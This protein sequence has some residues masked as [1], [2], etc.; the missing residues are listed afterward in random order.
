MLTKYVLLPGLPAVYIHVL[1]KLC[2]LPYVAG[3]S[4][5]TLTITGSGFG[6]DDDGVTV[7][8]GMVDCDVSDVTDTQVTCTPEVGPVG[9]AE[10]AVN[11]ATKG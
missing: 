10:V 8:I 9:E 1:L 2:C 4:D 7:T 11:V 5:V 6:E 3:T